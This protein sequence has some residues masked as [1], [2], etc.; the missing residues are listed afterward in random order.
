MW[1]KCGKGKEINLIKNIE[2]EGDF[3]DDKK[4]WIWKRKKF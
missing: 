3:K 4:K 2:Y 1:K